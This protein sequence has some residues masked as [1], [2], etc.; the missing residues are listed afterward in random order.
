VQGG[1]P[2][3]TITPL[4][5]LTPVSR[6]VTVG[7]FANGF[8]YYTREN[9]E[10]RNRAELRL[11]VKVGSIVG[12]DDQRGLAHFLEDMAFNGTENFE[13]QELVRFMESIGMRLGQGLN[14]STWFDET[15]TQLTCRSKTFSSS[16]S[17]W[18]L[19][20]SRFMRT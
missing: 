6:K 17:D 16:I 14:A 13:K 11:V 7:R 4:D 8:R 2:W 10:P 18:I 1:Y 20:A 5:Q 12:D 3:T 9:R 19:G 15:I